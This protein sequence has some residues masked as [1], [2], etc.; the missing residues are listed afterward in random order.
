MKNRL[1]AI[2]LC[3]FSISAIAQTENGVNSN[4]KAKKIKK[5]NE[6]LAKYITQLYNSNPFEGVKIVEEK[7][8][9]YLLSLSVQVV[10]GHKTSS[11]MNRVAHIKASRNAMV[12]LNGSNIIS[13][14]IIKTGETV[15]NNS[16][17]YYETY[18]DEIKENAAG[19][20]D[21]MQVLTTFTS[22][23]GKEYIYIIYKE[24]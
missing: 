20:L 19:F 18:I 16:V 8:V 3:V 7:D 11:T 22:N 5:N 17:S 23:N 6:Q 4:F 10:S 21:G 13:E 1:L 12:F 2:L 9:S 15:T 24:L 14:T